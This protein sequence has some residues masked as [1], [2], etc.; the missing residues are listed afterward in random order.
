MGRINR[1]Q[2]PIPFEAGVH[3]WGGYDVI[4]ASMVEAAKAHGQVP[5][6]VSFEGA[7]PTLLAHETALQEGTR[8]QRRWL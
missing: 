7:L 2:G 4:R 8:S 3:G 5:R 1:L 6:R